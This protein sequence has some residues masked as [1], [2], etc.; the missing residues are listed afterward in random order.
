MHFLIE[1]ILPIDSNEWITDTTKRHSLKGMGKLCKRV[2]KLPSKERTALPPIV[3]PHPGTSYNPSYADHQSL[4]N[5]VIKKESE[6]IKEEAHLNRV[7][8]HMLKK[9]TGQQKN[10]STVC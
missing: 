7:T 2:S 1:N 5:E 10:V 8:K 9:F 4:L 3:P 6:L